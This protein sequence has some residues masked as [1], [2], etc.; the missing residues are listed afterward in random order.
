MTNHPMPPEH[1]P[2]FFRERWKRLVGG[3]IYPIHPDAIHSIDLHLYIPLLIFQ[4]IAASKCGLGEKK[5]GNG[6]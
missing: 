5:N 1:S 3:I 2:K 6:A 4:G